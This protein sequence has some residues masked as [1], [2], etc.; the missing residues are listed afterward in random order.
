MVA[1]NGRPPTRSRAA[2]IDLCEDFDRS[3]AR[4]CL[5]AARKA[6]RQCSDKVEKPACGEVCGTPSLPGELEVDLDPTE[7]GLKAAEAAAAGGI[8]D[9]G[10]PVDAAEDAALMT[11]I[12][13][14]LSSED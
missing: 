3:A 5:R 1:M 13:A 12:E 11:E 14:V 6:E 7:R 2:R 10:E 9:D 4:K 8:V